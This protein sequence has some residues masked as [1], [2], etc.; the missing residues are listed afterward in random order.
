MDN[1]KSYSRRNFLKVGSVVGSGLVI[2]FHFPFGN[3]LMAVEIKEFKP[4]TFI[5][6]LP[7]DRIIISVAKA[8]MGQ[9]VWTSLPMLVAEEMEAD[10]SKIK[11]VQGNDAEFVGTGG[12][13][14]ISGYG[15][16]KMREAGAIAK[17]ML[18]EAASKK[19]KVIPRECEA[20]N[21]M[22][23][24]KPSG[25][26]LS[27]GSLTDQASKLKIPRKVKLKDPE[28]YTVVGQ[29]KLR[30][31]SFVKTNGTAPYS[32]DVDIDG[33]VYA[34]V[35]K[36]TPF[37]AKYISS[38][39]SDV[40][41]MHGVLDVFLTPNGVA[42]V[43]KNT[44]SVMKARKLLKVN[45][46]KKEPVNNDS[47]LYQDHMHALIS[48]KAKSVRKEGN[49][50]KVLKEKEDLFEVKYSLPFQTHA[51]MEPLNCVVDVKSNS[52]EIWVGTQN[53]NNA[54]DRAHK[55]TGIDKKNIKLNITFLGGGFGRKAFN[56]W[57]D[58]GLYIS[59][60]IKKPTKLIWMRED[61]TKHGFYRPSSLHHMVGA[62]KNKKI[63]LWKHKV[64]SPDALGQQMVY[65]YGASLPGIAKGVMKL[66][67]VKGM[68]SEIITEGAKNINYD[69][70]NMLIEMKVFETDVPLG[71][72]RAVYDSQNAFANE[73]FIDE[74][75]YIGE[76]DPVE[77]RLKHLDSNSRSS[78]VIKKAA[79][80]SGWGKKF[81]TGNSQGFAYHHSFGT[82]V[83]EVAEVSILKSNKVKVHKVTCV[84]DCGQTVKPMTIRAQMQGAIVYGLGATLKSEIT[85][86][87]GQVDQS[88]YDDYEVLRMNEMPQIDV[89]I[90][91]NN[92]DPGGVGEPGLP[93]IAP[94]IANAVFAATRK[95]IRKLPI[96]PKNLK[97]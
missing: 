81:E 3:K 64:I 33:M 53:A 37:G 82:H 43:G 76:V 41:K 95:R 31:D 62:I 1:V 63:N 72:W 55:I 35:E 57:I 61:D 78:I 19:W 73:C 46:A 96:T 23:Y 5:R 8:E 91:K 60:K 42:I 83:A 2:G 85:I 58:E 77:L 93:P 24:H 18:I 48:E 97:V 13:N 49:P 59:Q 87:N 40:K 79:K 52:C 90:I 88:N 86:K 75:S 47:D 15:W 22:V 17:H 28:N 94:A 36:P 89:H 9:G 7:D 71:F 34:M 25:K 51:A 27:F 21:S 56:D 69:F 29:D 32:M 67:I 54:I 12:S 68:M 30:T 80:E 66:G 14:S 65:Q 11:V 26:S 50:K 6:V 20:K 38:N 45:W 74:L 84:V 39:L 10:W 44:W 4:N 70:S 92:E 16:E